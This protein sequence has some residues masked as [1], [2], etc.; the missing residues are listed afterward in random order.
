MRLNEINPS[1]YDFCSFIPEKLQILLNLKKRQGKGGERKGREGYGKRDGE[2]KRDR[3]GE[4]EK[5]GGRGGEGRGRSGGERQGERGGEGE[6]GS[7]HKSYCISSQWFPAISCSFPSPPSNISMELAF[8]N[9]PPCG[10]LYFPK[11]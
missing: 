2:G 6:G 3:E 11:E 9:F 1:A 4:G 5:D 7:N 10:L 8:R